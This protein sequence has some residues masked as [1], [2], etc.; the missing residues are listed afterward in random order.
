MQING[1]DYRSL[2]YEED[3]L[4][5]IDQNLLPNEFE[6]KSFTDHLEVAEAIRIMTV[7]G[8]PAIG[9]AGAYGM[10][11]AI[12][13][14]PDEKFRNH[15]RKAHGTLIAARPTAIDLSIG[16]NK[17]YESALKFIPDLSYTRHVALLAAHEF[18]NN[19]VR[20]CQEIGVL[21]SQVVPPGARI[22]T[23][24]NAG[25]LATIDHGTAL[26]VIRQAHREGKNIFVYVDETR[27]RLQ[28]AR[29]TAFELE[30]EGIPHAIIT[31]AASGFYFWKGEIDMVIT[32]A[33]R[34]C[35]NGDIANKIGTYEKA[36]MA[37]VHDIPFYIAAP[38][39][40]FDFAC[41][42]GQD[43]PIEIRS[44]AEIK[45]IGENI[46]CNPGSAALN[47]AFDITPAKYIGGIITPKGIFEPSEAAQKVQL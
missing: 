2:W 11:L 3:A 15:I 21:G 29:L 39:S 38:V 41:V 32:G 40:T 7:R 46:I 35:L 47:P 31:D 42:R 10:A 44:E 5:M 1:K 34:I 14:A 22:L 8:A 45:R 36:V 37:Q 13:N 30:Q 25:A 26:A 24:C 33:D 17:V 4:K 9:A 6:I 28:G 18:A 19:I 20:E 23:H 27:P 12:L 16:V 43:I